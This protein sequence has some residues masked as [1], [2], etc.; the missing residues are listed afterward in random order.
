M[1]GNIPHCGTLNS[2][3]LFRNNCSAFLASRHEVGTLFK[4]GLRLCKNQKKPATVCDDASSP[5]IIPPFAAGNRGGARQKVCR[6]RRTWHLAAAL[7]RSLK[8]GFGFGGVLD[9]RVMLPTPDNKTC[10]HSGKIFDYAFASNRISLKPKVR[11][12]D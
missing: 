10:F 12:T 8:R 4:D 2:R 1:R 6:L 11:T 3:K 7:C 9:R 5:K